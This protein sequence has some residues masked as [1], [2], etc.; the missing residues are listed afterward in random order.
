MALALPNK[1]CVAV[2]E[3]LGVEKA[4]VLGFTLVCHVNEVVELHVRRLVADESERLS[5]VLEQY[6]VVRKGLDL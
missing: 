6:E 2:L 4:N 5:E 3:A 1:F